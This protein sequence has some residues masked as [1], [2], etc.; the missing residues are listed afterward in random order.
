M[1]APRVANSLTE[2]DIT[3]GEYC[4][5]ERRRSGHT[6]EWWAEQNAMSVD[7][8]RKREW[9]QRPIRLT[10]QQVTKASNMTLSPGEYC[11]LAR[12]RAMVRK[13]E[14]AER[15]GVTGMTLWKMEH[16]KTSTS[17]NLARWWRRKGVPLPVLG[18]ETI[19][20]ALA[21]GIYA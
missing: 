21:P 1:S 12:R 3:L 5:L 20:M 19:T 11:A 8:V 4:W 13:E 16:D 14:V 18:A 7:E 15:Y 17:I 2:M 10:Y 6:A 9:D